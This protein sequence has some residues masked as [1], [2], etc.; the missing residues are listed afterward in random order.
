MP[1][2]AA[3]FIKAGASLPAF[4]RE[5]ADARRRLNIKRKRM[6]ARSDLFGLVAQM[7]EGNILMLAFMGRVIRVEQ[8]REEMRV[9]KRVLGR[10]RQNVFRM[11]LPLR[12][13]LERVG[14][15]AVDVLHLKGV[16]VADLVVRAAVISALDHDDVTSWTTQ[17]DGVTLARE[18]TP[19]QAKWHGCPAE[20]WKR[21]RH[22]RQKYNTRLEVSWV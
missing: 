2:P 15:I 5:P 6:R 21:E 9:E 10:E 20:S 18:L 3:R 22:F 8:M 17:V 19:Y 1:I 11:N 7:A 16:S 13:D 4:S 14:E 12:H